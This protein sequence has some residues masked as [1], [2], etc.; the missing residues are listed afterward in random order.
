MVVQMGIYFF[1]HLDILKISQRSHLSVYQKS[2]ITLI[3]CNKV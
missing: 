2:L 3:E 1:L